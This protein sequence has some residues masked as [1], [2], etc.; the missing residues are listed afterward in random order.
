VLYI[1][2]GDQLMAI[3]RY[4]RWFDNAVIGDGISKLSRHSCRPESVVG[5][6]SGC[7]IVPAGEVTDF[8]RGYAFVGIPAAVIASLSGIVLFLIGMLP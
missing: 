6:C 5:S 1:D 2:R 3:V 8:Y 7:A 4:L